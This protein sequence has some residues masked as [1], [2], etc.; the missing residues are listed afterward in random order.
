MIQLKATHDEADTRLVLHA[1][2]GQF[3]TVVVSSRDIGVLVFPRVQCER[4]WVLSGTTKKK[5]I[6]IDAVFN[7]LLKDKTTNLLPSKG[8]HGKST[9]R[10]IIC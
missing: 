10:T 5:Y 3:N 1:V 2:H 6:P 4:F 8:P 9:K 7:N